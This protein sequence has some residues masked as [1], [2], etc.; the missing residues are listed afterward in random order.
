MQSNRLGLLVFG[1]HP[2]DCDIKA[3]GLAILYAQMGHR[4]RFVSVANG[5]AGHHEQGGAILA[6]RR[7]AE[8]RRAGDVAGI[9]Y[10]TLDNHDGELEPTLENRR[11]LIRII[12]EFEPDLVLTPRPWDYHPDHRYASV[13]VQDSAYLV[14][15]PNICADVRHLNYNPV[16]AYVSDG[17]Q[18][19]LPFQPTVAIGIDEVVERKL[20][21]LHCHTSQVYEWLP[22]NG[23]YLAEVPEDEAERRQWLAERWN[24]RSS[25]DQYRDLLVKLYGEEEGGRFRFAEAFEPCEYGSPL[26]DDNMRTL[27]PMLPD[28]RA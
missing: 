7:T 26:T 9:E 23:G 20:D 8:A 15:V 25:A 5:D 2:D 6:Q 19:P 3:G 27:F 13:L 22:Y 1:A 18:K 21:M 12:R 17:F 11:K 16:I 24:R 4:V 10:I 28:A 14:T